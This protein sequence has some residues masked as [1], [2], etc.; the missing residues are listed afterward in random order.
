VHLLVELFL[1]AV[2]TWIE[3]HPDSPFSRFMLAQRGPRTDVARMTRVQRL[4]SA[5]SFLLWGGLFI[6]LWLL[7]AYLTFGLGVLSPE[8]TAVQVLSFGLALLAGCG[9]VGGLYLLV[10]ALV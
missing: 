4:G 3:R 9:V 8:S 7:V 2:V 1:K 6:G 10:R 5:I